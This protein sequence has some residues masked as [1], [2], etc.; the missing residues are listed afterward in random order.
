MEK[1]RRKT[2]FIRNPGIYENFNK[3]MASLYMILFLPYSPF[4][5]NL[6]LL[7]FII[8][9]PSINININ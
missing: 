5:L 3:F 4:P 7:F 2:N 8:Y 6:F 1:G 9:Q